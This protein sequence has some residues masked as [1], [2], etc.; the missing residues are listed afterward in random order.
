M[1]AWGKQTEIKLKMSQ[2]QELAALT[3]ASGPRRGK[4]KKKGE[5]FASAAENIAALV[6]ILVDPCEMKS[7]LLSRDNHKPA[8]LNAGRVSVHQR[9]SPKEI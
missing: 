6:C 9:S 4:K 2:T 3:A 7:P 1:E 8:F 5:R